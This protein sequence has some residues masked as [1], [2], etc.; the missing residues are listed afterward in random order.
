MN[1]KFERF[2]FSV[3]C[4][5]LVF[6]FSF[7]KIDAGPVSSD[8]YQYW[9]I[10]TH[11]AK[12]GE[13]GF[14]DQVNNDIEDYANPLN[15]SGIR[16][17]ESLYPFIISSLI[18]LITT[19]NELM[20]INSDCIYGIND[21]LCPVLGGTSVLVNL[22]FTS[23]KYLLIFF[24]SYLFYNKLSKKRIIFLAL[25]LSVTFPY[26]NKDL[27]TYTFL[28]FYF[29]SYS[30]LFTPKIQNILRYVSLS[31]LP[32]TNP[33]FFYYL[34]IRFFIV[35]FLIFKDK[36]LNKTKIFLTL[37]CI[38][39]TMFWATRNFI[40]ENDFT[41]TSRGSEII[42]IRAEF[43]SIEYQ[44]IPAGI[45]YYTP[46]NRVTNI[47][48]GY[49]WNKVGSSENWEQLFD[50]SNEN[51]ILRLGHQKRG[52]VYERMKQ[53]LN[54]KNLLY[55]DV[56]NLYGYNFATN[57]YRKASFNLIF[58]NKV[59]Y[60][61]TSSMFLYR[62][63]FPEFNQLKENVKDNLFGSF[64]NEILLFLRFFPI[65]YSFLY[66]I[67]NFKKSIYEIE[68]YIFLYIFFSYGMLTHFIPRY[69]TLLIPFTI[70]LYLQRVSL[71]NV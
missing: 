16:R 25:L 35:C 10:A 65:I 2:I 15:N 1:L 67:L 46:S 60:L 48:T 4:A 20:S 18:K 14:L 19:K 43:I 13:Y 31:L 44:D 68:N 7:P 62:G 6:L 61:S 38:V 40:Q 32:L 27:M 41:I 39:P 50:R 8:D 26:T 22:L 56:V 34:F 54:L 5:S 59:K 66:L 58:D 17:G 42:G 30:D 23:L 28:L 37:L 70:Y 29:I 71:K 51:S 24:T 64:L 53:N 3:V 49:L 63:L 52:Y 47:F 69:G 12:T 33:I 11:L 9:Y 36:K 45:I 55:A 21:G 57:E